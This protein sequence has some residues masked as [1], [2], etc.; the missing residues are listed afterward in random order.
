MRDTS[1]WAEPFGSV[2]NLSNAPADATPEEI[3]AHQRQRLAERASPARLRI[4]KLRDAARAVIAAENA[5]LDARETFAMVSQFFGGLSDPLVNTGGSHSAPGQF[6]V[7]VD[8]VG[9][10]DVPA[11]V[12]LQQFV[13]VA[14]DG[15]QQNPDL[16]VPVSQAA[17]PDESR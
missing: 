12:P 16:V 8:G 10:S 15:E 9:L 14:Q 1:K 11:D 2:G 7:L 17:P 5:L 3:M 13:D 6:S 4:E